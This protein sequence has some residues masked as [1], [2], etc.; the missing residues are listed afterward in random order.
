MHKKSLRNSLLFTSAALLVFM[1]CL[2][3][4]TSARRSPLADTT[5]EQ[6]QGQPPHALG[7]TVPPFFN[8][9][10]KWVDSVF[11]AMTED[12]RI[13]QL[14]MVAAYSKNGTAPSDKI[15]NLIQQ[16]KIGG[17]I[18]MQGGP[19]RQAVLTNY[20]QSISSVPLMIGID[21]EWGLA[22]RLDSTMKFPW[23]MTLGAVQDDKL[24]YDM[25]A[26]IA[27]QCKRIGIQGLGVYREY[28]GSGFSDALTLCTMRLKQALCSRRKP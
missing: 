18:F 6:M 5:D 21:G 16:Q 19:G 26:V 13:G 9:K 12:E 22:M 20:Y 15:V 17:L 4:S 11:N 3:T 27:D 8:V 25:G 14:F 7:D 1:S 2:Y 28:E 10:N 24:I 23:Q